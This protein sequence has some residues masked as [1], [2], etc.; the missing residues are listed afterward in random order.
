MHV[1]QCRKRVAISFELFSPS[2]CFKSSFAI[3]IRATDFRWC[4]TLIKPWKNSIRFSRSAIQSV[5]YRQCDRWKDR[6][7]Y[8]QTIDFG[9]S[10]WDWLQYYDFRKRRREIGHSFGVFIRSYSDLWKW[11]ENHKVLSGRKTCKQTCLECQTRL[12][13]YQL[14]LVDQ[15]SFIKNRSRVLNNVREYFESS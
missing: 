8:W 12:G 5:K 9:F 1:H 11:S 3:E 7:I 4:F 13:L 6:L 2:H 14:K 10:S 15:S